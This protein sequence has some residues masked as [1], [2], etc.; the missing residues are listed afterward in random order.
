ME[1]LYKVLDEN[2]RAC[3]GGKGEWFLPRKKRDGTWTPGK[4]MPKIENISLCERGYH[5]CRRQD[6][7]YWLHPTIYEVE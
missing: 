1:L 6:L 3:H 7:I 5:L 2:G 4:W